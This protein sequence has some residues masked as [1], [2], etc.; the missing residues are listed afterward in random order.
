MGD[1]SRILVHGYGTSQMKINGNVTRI[2][3]SLYVL[4]L[5]SDLFSVTNTG[6]W[7]TVTHSSLKE[8]ICID[9]SQNF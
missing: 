8:E 9:R 3:N 5:D 7:T 1:E 2:V 4:G 6:A